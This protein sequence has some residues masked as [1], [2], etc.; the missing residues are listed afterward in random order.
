[1]IGLENK[2]KILKKKLIFDQNWLLFLSFFLRLYDFNTANLSFIILALYSF[3]GPIQI[4]Q[5][6]TLCFF[7]TSFNY[8]FIDNYTSPGRVFA[9]LCF[10]SCLI[11][12]LKH[13][14]FKY[15][16]IKKIIFK[17]NIL[18]ITIL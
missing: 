17:S 9:Y 3:L 18:F 10:F 1:M 6:L 8:T 4:I 2:V 16:E 7:F 15:S 5:S 13:Y 11:S 12:I 14:D